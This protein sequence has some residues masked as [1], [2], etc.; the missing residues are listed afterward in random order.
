[1]TRASDLP[2]VDLAPLYTRGEPGLREV[3]ATLGRACRE[4]G[5]FYLAGARVPDALRVAAF[6][7]AR[8]FFAAPASAKA[9]VSIARSRHNRGYVGL[10]VEA[11]DPAGGG[12]HKEAFNI[13]LELAPD[14]PERLADK[15]FR[16]P[17]LWPELPGFRATLLAY[18]D[19]L[20]DLGRDVHRAV[21]ADLGLAPGYF[22]DKLARPLATLRLLRYPPAPADVAQ[23][24]LGAGTHTDYGN[25]T[26]LA[27]DSVGGLEVRRRDGTWMAAPPVPGAFICNI[28]DC[29]MR[30]TNDVYVS[31]PHRVVSPPGRERF[32]IAF[33]LDADPDV[34]VACLPTCRGDGRDPKYPPVTVANYL[35]G[36]LDATYRS[37][38]GS[39]R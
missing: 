4:V 33:F 5:F 8:A 30:W 13:G 37:A 27:T 39:R 6:D 26:L 17:N 25:L 7:A 2:V 16:G 9:S 20:L 31:T 11:L 21:A 32:S 24:R 28:G 3:A 36:R 12:D 19:A 1:M 18:Y 22:D 29:L 10:A 34:E 23:D 35:R 15:P 38:P 14:D